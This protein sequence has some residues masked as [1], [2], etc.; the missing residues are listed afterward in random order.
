MILHT[1]LSQFLIFRNE[2]RDGMKH[3]YDPRGKP[4]LKLK[5][6]TF[7]IY[8]CVLGQDIAM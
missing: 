8:Y 5:N 1:L 7:L 6:K 2:L 3:F 4:G